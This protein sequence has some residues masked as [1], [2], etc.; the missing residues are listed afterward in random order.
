MIVY[1]LM[2]EKVSV[3]LFGDSFFMTHYVRLI[4][5]NIKVSVPLF[6][7]SF[8]ITTGW[9]VLLPPLAS[10]R[11]LIRGFFFYLDVSGVNHF[12]LTSVS[13]PLFGDSFFIKM[14]ERELADYSAGVSVPLF[15]DSFFIPCQIRRKGG[16]HKFPSPYS[17]ILFLSLWK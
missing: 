2:D 13:V 5:P 11:P 10:F 17:G 7:D 16:K 4:F 1:R 9:N 14:S 3:P 6:G 8:F 12:T 15:G